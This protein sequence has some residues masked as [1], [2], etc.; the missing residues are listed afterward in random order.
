MEVKIEQSVD[1]SPH[2]ADASRPHAP[3]GDEV[4]STSAGTNKAVHHTHSHHSSAHGPGSYAHARYS[5]QR[6]ALQ[7]V[8]HARKHAYLRAKQQYQ[9]PPAKKARTQKLV[10]IGV[11]VDKEPAVVKEV[12]HQSSLHGG[13]LRARQPH[14]AHE[15]V[16]S[17]VP[18]REGGADGM[19]A[20][21]RAPVSRRCTPS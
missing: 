7:I 21:L 15:G 20:S 11:S 1:A 2:M 3:P 13:T 8:Q 12:R 5:K 17:G 16:W 14:A 18:C 10:P 9:P 4:A 6:H 19:M